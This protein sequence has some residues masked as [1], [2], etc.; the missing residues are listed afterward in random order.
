MKNL[1]CAAAA[2]LGFVWSAAPALAQSSIFLLD[3]QVDDEA[4]IYRLDPRSGEMSFLGALDVAGEE[5]TGL[6][7]E[8]ED[9]LYVSTLAGTIVR[10]DLAPSFNANVLGNVGGG[11]TDMQYDGGLLYVVDENSDELS[12]IEIDPLNKTTIGKVRVGDSTGPV[13]D[14]IGGDISQDSSG[15]WYLVTNSANSESAHARLYR[16]D[17]GTAVATEVGGILSTGGRITGMVFDRS[18]GDRL[19][20]A[21]RELDGLVI[22][23]PVSGCTVETVSLCASCP[24]P[25]D[26]RAG[27]LAL[28]AGDDATPAGIQSPTSRRP[29]PTPL[30]CGEP[31]TPSAAA[32]THTPT[33]IVQRT[34]SEGCIGDCDRDGT[35]RV[36]ELLLGV[37]IGLGVTAMESCPS[38]DHNRSGTVS[39]DELLRA[40]TNALDGCTPDQ[41]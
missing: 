19:Y 33:P 34:P 27:D 5:A 29:T 37:N 7:A 21:A 36:N 11:L 28:V 10:V 40:V 14:I 2:L 26:L 12:A 38:C 25:F 31:P 1:L 23:D 16:L 30:L 22:A 15:N 8:N 20:L 6:A 41:S 17:M 4:A 24:A 9:T 18:D 3:S 39:I 35:V 32:R 13:L